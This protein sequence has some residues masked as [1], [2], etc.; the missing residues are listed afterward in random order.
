MQ[1]AAARFPELVT[2]AAGLPQNFFHNRKNPDCV[3]SN[4]A[5]CV[6]WAVDNFHTYVGPAL[7]QA[8]K[9]LARR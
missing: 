9:S 8:M 2:V 4:G 6:G 3:Q 7:K 5:F 1:P